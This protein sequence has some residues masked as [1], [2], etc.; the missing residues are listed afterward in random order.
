MRLNLK[1]HDDHAWVGD[2]LFIRTQ[3]ERIVKTERGDDE[4]WLES[5]EIDHIE[6]RKHASSVFLCADNGPVMDMYAVTCGIIHPGG[7]CQLFLRKMA[8]FQ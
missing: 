7:D 8:T 6:D 4:C 1:F 3:A 2:E 5:D